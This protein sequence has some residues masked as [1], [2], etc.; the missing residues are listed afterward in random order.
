MVT[1]GF[2]QSEANVSHRFNSRPGRTEITRTRVY[3]IGRK[4][5]LP[6]V[7]GAQLANVRVSNI[8]LFSA[9][10]KPETAKIV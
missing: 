6:L 2:V 7:G 10:M 5:N 8:V 4:F 9:P 3:V 1:D